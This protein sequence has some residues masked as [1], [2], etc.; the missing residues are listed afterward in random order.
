MNN[1]KALIDLTDFLNRSSKNKM[2]V[3][4]S[5]STPV[6]KKLRKRK[7]PDV[8]GNKLDGWLTKK[9]VKTPP[10]KKTRTSPRLSIKLS[11]TKQQKQVSKRLQTESILERKVLSNQ[12][13][14]LKGDITT[15]QQKSVLP[16]S[17]SEPKRSRNINKESKKID[18]ID[19]EKEKNKAVS[20]KTCTPNSGAKVSKS[21]RPKKIDKIVEIG[22]KKKT[23]SNEKSSPKSGTKSNKPKQCNN[24][25]RKDVKNRDKKKSASIEISTPISTKANKQTSLKS[26]LTK[27]SSKTFNRNDSFDS[28]E[29]PSFKNITRR[30]SI[31]SSKRKDQK[32]SF[33][34][35]GVILPTVD[36]ILKDKEDLEYRRRKIECFKP[37]S[38][39]SLELPF[40]NE[41]V[42]TP[43]KEKGL[44]CKHLSLD[45]LTSA[46]N[47]Y[48]S[49]LSDII[50]E[51]IGHSRHQKYFN[52]SLKVL[53]MSPNDLTYNTSTIAFSYE[54]LE[55][56]M[57]LLKQQF[58]PDDMKTKYFFQVLL[59]ELCLR[60][61]MK[62]YA[63]D[64]EQAVEY[65]NERPVI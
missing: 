24:T 2:E 7:Y 45:E 25:D 62:T 44:D 43:T 64:L 49:L 41:I 58:D 61:F 9:E 53:T 12:K 65:L 32:A 33:Q 42:Q 8:Q 16:N 50:G 17:S 54:Q 23:V 55:H 13:Y 19:D 21:K 57:S 63:M 52:R 26:F 1:H 51:K 10:K 59:P 28:V 18:K 20:N 46:F 48:V 34:K 15:N 11:R 39:D 4:D 14:S 5:N 37:I 30:K 6:S 56:L 22:V 3:G 36:E 31:K 27:T 60:I 40:F 38:E 47:T 29:L 35:Y